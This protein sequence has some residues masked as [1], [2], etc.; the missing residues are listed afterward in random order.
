MM[1]HSSISL[2]H[3]SWF[4]VFALATWTLFSIIKLFTIYLSVCS[5]V[6]VYSSIEGPTPVVGIGLL[7]ISCS[8]LVFLA[9]WY[10]NRRT[11]MIS[12]GRAV[13]ESAHEIRFFL[14]RIIANCWWWL[15]Y[16]TCNIHYNPPRD[17][18]YALVAR[19]RALWNH[20]W[21]CHCH[22][23]RPGHIIII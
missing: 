7:H 21:S 18:C 22:Y 11:L 19:R 20:T 10:A 9:S 14:L 4:S 1:L 13:V 12:S 3:S 15:L 23:D 6:L 17:T 5:A 16:L 8:S 2:I